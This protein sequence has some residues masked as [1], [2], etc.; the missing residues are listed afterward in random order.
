M[1]Q[2]LLSVRVRQYEL[3]S[4]SLTSDILGY[5]RCG[6][7][8]R[9]TRLGKMPARSP[10][11][12]WFGHFI[13]GCMDEGF[14]RYRTATAK[15]IPHSK[16]MSAVDP[17]LIIP[18]VEERLLNQGLAA[19]E[20]WTKLLG[21]SRARVALR[22]LGTHLFPLISLSEVRLTGAR[23]LKPLPLAKAFRRADRYEMAGIIDVVTDVEM[24]K[25]KANHIV[26]A[27]EAKLRALPAQFEL[28]VD[29]KGSRRAPIVAP[30][31][32]SGPSLWDQYAWQVLTYAELRARQ[33][34]SKPVAAGVLVHINELLPLDSDL[35]ELEKEVSAA[36]TRGTSLGTDEKVDPKSIPAWRKIAKKAAE[37]AEAEQD[38]LYN[39]GDPLADLKA[40]ALLTV[41]AVPWEVRLRRS[42]RIVPN[43]PKERA[44][45]LVAFD[46]TV[47]SIECSRGG[48]FHGNGVLASWPTNPND[49]STCSACD[50]RTWCPSFSKHYGGGK[51]VLPEIP[52]AKVRP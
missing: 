2:V 45:S 6:L 46:G 4:Y 12:L 51:S 50:S 28:I 38:R 44:A 35:F 37:D 19:W 9:Y 47:Y 29:Y 15:G 22:E 32:G 21:Y 11:Q 39:A 20:P 41:T 18:F 42:L 48:E 34:G 13:H 26:A 7:Q 27:A 1:A 49:K 10:L 14:R 25:H 17:D 33:V 36:G 8:Y 3:P 16:A 23:G 43:E 52:R 31:A 5:M 30:R 40:S 24:S